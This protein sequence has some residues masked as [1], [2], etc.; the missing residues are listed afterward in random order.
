MSLQFRTLPVAVGRELNIISV[1][2]CS[3]VSFTVRIGR[4][5]SA[6]YSAT[7]SLESLTD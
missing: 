2:Y 6:V 5:L 3:N 4:I 1:Y 7:A